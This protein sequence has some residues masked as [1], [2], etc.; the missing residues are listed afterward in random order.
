LGVKTLRKLLVLA[1]GP[2]ILTLASVFFLVFELTETTVRTELDQLATT[3]LTDEARHLHDVFSQAQSSLRLLALSQ[4]IQQGKIESIVP[5]LKL[6]ATNFPQ[7][8]EALYYNTAA[9]DVYG[10][11]DSTFN[12]SDRPYFSQ[13]QKGETVVTKVMESRASRQPVILVLLPVFSA[14]SKE[15]IGAIGVTILVRNILSKISLI[16]PGFRGDVLLIDENGQPISGRKHSAH[17][18]DSDNETQIIVQSIGNGKEGRERVQLTKAKS[19]IYYQS[20][21]VAHWRLAFI[22]SDAEVFFTRRL[23]R[24]TLLMFLA[25]SLP[26]IFLA[27]LRVKKDI[28]GPME[29]LAISEERWRSLVQNAPFF[30]HTIDE[31]GTILFINQVIPG[32]EREKVIGSK[33]YDYATP[34][35]AAIMRQALEALFATGQPQTYE[36]SAVGKDGNSSWYASTMSPMLENG[37][38]TKAVLIAFD[39]T[40]RRQAEEKAAQSER[41][42]RGIF[43]QTF[44]F[45]GLLAPDGT[46]LEANEAALLFIEKKIEDVRGKLFWDTPWWSHSPSEQEKVK[47]GLAEAARG[48]YVHFETHHRSPSGKLTTIDFSL[49]PIFDEQSKLLWIIPEGHDITVLKETVEALRRSEVLFRSIVNDQTEMIV[50]WKPDGTRTF[51]NDAYCRIFNQTKEQLIGSS[52]YPLISPEDLAD[53]KAKIA[54]LSPLQPILTDIHR[55]ILPNGEVGWQE[56]TDHA[57]FDAQ[58]NIVDI[59]SVGRDIS[60]RVRLEKAQR[61]TEAN[62]SALVENIPG[63]IWSVDKHYRYISFNSLFRRGVEVITGQTPEVG[64][65]VDALLP[66]EASAAWKTQFDRALSGQ[67]FSAEYPL[68]V[69]NELRQ[70]EVSFNP[71]RHGDEITGV[72]VLSIDITARKAAEEVLRLQAKVLE[73]MTEGVGVCDENAVIIYTNSAEERMFGYEHD[74]LLGRKAHILVQGDEAEVI[75]LHDDIWDELKRSGHFSRELQNRRKD[76]S[77]FYSFVSIST[78]EFA[79]RRCAV[80]VREDITERRKL[81][82]RLLQSQKMESIGQLAGGVAHDFNNILTV[83]QGHAGILQL[84]GGMHAEAA[85]AAAEIVRASDRASSLT[86]QLLAFSRQQIMQPKEIALSGIV[87]EM[88]KMLQ[89]L[90]GEHITLTLETDPALPMVKADP[91]MM[92]QIVLNLAVNARDAM[93]TGGTL[94]INLRAEHVTSPEASEIKPLSTLHVCL[95][96]TDTGCGIPEE[97]LPRIFDPFFT[98]KEVGKGTGLGLATVYGIVKQHKGW[99]EVESV[100]GQ[101]STFRVYLPALNR[102]A[103]ATAQMREA[104]QISRGTEKIMIV[105]DEI[106]LRTLVRSILKHLGYQVV[107]AASAKDALAIWPEHKESVALVLTDL[108]MPDGMSGIALAEILSRDKPSLRVIYSSGYSSEM[109]LQQ[110]NLVPNSEFLAKPYRPHQLAELIRRMLDAPAA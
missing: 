110:E 73:S 32:L 92:Q 67:Q 108:V 31:K 22:Y 46:T 19:T 53:V 6:W 98:T 25:V 90:L 38:V 49:K 51:V 12:V 91:G 83:I 3:Q 4:V 37:K 65:S 40:A 9:G 88:T 96:V 41:R 100:S 54:R 68:M 8:I 30:I 104:Y 45:I 17:G 84:M 5:Q 85:D 29:A 99:V 52:F 11:D 50:R 63:A 44:Q 56:W 26:F 28:T 55:G 21:P 75:K 14:D 102:T 10:S 33:I 109:I 86:K 97:N 64:T 101:G 27:V 80:W 94:K 24:N 42:F 74:E 34:E 47:A 66:A 76:G 43:N 59:Q 60:E 77:H 82:Q 57:H 7:P 35:N 107:E 106:S 18:K 20:I 16:D 78:L 72:T 71:I 93:P 81:E 23:V 87:S 1:F 79:G 15:R 39:I 2:V 36:L 89:R 103:V 95:S 62:L 48:K 58:G 105:E 13:I 61:T 69:R 70:Y